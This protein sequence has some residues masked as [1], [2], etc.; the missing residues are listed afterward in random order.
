MGANKVN[1]RSTPWLRW[2]V[3]RVSGS[4]WLMP[5][6]SEYQQYNR[7]MPFPGARASCFSKILQSCSRGCLGSGGLFCCVKEEYREISNNVASIKSTL[8]YQYRVTYCCVHSR[9]TVVTRSNPSVLTWD[10]RHESLN[11][12]KRK[13]K[14]LSASPNGSFYGETNWNF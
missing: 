8:F 6:N 7:L 2:I 9:S 3:G 14:S 11:T 12:C 1:A 4:F 5:R 10:C 13:F